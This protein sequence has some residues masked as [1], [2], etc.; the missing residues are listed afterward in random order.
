MLPR[1]IGEL[2]PRNKFK[3]KTVERVIHDTV[4]SNGGGLFFEDLLGKLPSKHGNISIKNPDMVESI[5]QS[6]ADI[7]ILYYQGNVVK[8]FVYVLPKKI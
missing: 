8:R 6:M 7:K 1:M 3:K 2:V 4:I 5:I